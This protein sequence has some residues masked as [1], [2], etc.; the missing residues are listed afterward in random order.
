M[1]VVFFFSIFFYIF[2]E[3]F[4]LFLGVISVR[5]QQVARV[6]FVLKK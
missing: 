3:I 1:S 4:F 2:L 5:N 6:M